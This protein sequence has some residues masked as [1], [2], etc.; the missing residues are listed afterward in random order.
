MVNIAL[1][2]VI[3]TFHLS[4]WVFKQNNILVTRPLNPRLPCTQEFQTFLDQAHTLAGDDKW[5]ICQ[6]HYLT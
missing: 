2:S 6:P 5:L 3:S 4:N 1:Q